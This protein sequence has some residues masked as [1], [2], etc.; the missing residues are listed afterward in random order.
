MK[1]EVLG[2]LV[3]GALEQVFGVAGRPRVI[4]DSADTK[5]KVIVREGA[6]NIV[7][8]ELVPKG[9]WNSEQLFRVFVDEDTKSARYTLREAVELVATRVAI[10]R[11][12]PANTTT[13]WT[14]D[15][16]RRF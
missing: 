3:Q 15:G 2:D 14:K 9:R 4:V 16:Y 11:L 7:W 13:D 6:T 1:I 5:P 12:S 10:F 8:L